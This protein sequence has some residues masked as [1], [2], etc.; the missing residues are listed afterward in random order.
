MIIEGGL[1]IFEGVVIVG[2]RFCQMYL[3][4]RSLIDLRSHLKLTCKH[5]REAQSHGA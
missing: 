1:M 5:T 2:Y 4:T 3:Y